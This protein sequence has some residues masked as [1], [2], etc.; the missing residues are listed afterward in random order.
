MHANHA[1]SSEQTKRVSFATG[2]L[3]E[4]LAHVR[5]VWDDAA[6]KTIEARYL[7]PHADAARQLVND[8]TERDDHVASARQQVGAAMT[9]LDDAERAAQE[10]DEHLDEAERTLDGLQATLA[11]TT[12]RAER[13]HQDAIESIR[14]ANL[15]RGGCDGCPEPDGCVGLPRSEPLDRAAWDERRSHRRQ[16]Q[17]E[18]R[19]AELDRLQAAHPRVNVTHVLEGEFNKDGAF[20]GAHSPRSRLAIPLSRERQDARGV[21]EVLVAAK[22][23]SG[24]ITVKKYRHTVF[25]ETWS[26]NDICIEVGKAFLAARKVDRKGR[27]HQTASDGTLLRGYAQSDGRAVAHPI[28]KESNH[29]G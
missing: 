22:R 23:P 7:R 15:A 10:L 8:L 24:R 17:T 14:L 1:R 20:T 13:A 3:A 16:R 25:P 2:R 12:A 29:V 19:A 11:A 6:G 9:D 18:R 26:D 21:T 27:W 4:K 5:R 28:I